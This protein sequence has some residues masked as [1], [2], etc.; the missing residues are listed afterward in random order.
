M[1]WWWCHRQ[2]ST[3][4][5]R[6]LICILDLFYSCLV[7]LGKKPSMVIAGAS[8]SLPCSAWPGARLGCVWQWHPVLCDSIVTPKGCA[9]LPALSISPWFEQ[10]LCILWGDPEKAQCVRGEF[11]GLSGNPER[12][13]EGNGTFRMIRISNGWSCARI[14]NPS[15]QSY[16]KFCSTS[17]FRTLFLFRYSLC[18]V[19]SLACFFY[20][21]AFLNVWK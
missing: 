15:F 17:N 1:I 10:L 7:F 14:W 8:Q 13:S 6:S 20:S 5:N 3:A 4:K 21:Y 18:L 16:F 2:P 11:E 9:N 19:G 12:F